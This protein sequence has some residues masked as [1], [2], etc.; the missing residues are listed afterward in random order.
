MSKAGG[1]TH[2]NPR[3]PRRMT[4]R[5]WNKADARLCACGARIT[6]R[7]PKADKCSICY[8]RA[9]G[10]EFMSEEAELQVRHRAPRY[11]DGRRVDDE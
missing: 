3:V 2:S 8:E 5:E 4:R 11:M 10:G 6:N 1:E 9:R 7:N